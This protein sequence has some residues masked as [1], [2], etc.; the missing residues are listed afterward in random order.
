MAGEKTP[1]LTTKCSQCGFRT[2]KLKNGYPCSD[3]FHYDHFRPEE[4]WAHYKKP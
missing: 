4:E 3:C 1:V 2:R